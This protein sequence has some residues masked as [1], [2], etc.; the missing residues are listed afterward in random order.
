MAVRKKIEN[1]A[2]IGTTEKSLKLFHEN[3]WR[4]RQS[5]YKIMSLNGHHKNS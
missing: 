4:S 2:D 3:V 1:P 5:F